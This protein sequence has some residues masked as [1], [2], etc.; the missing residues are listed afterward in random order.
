MD[1]DEQ[2]YDASEAKWEMDNDK[3]WLNQAEYSS[4]AYD[5]MVR[6][7]MEGKS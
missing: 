4:E 5:E 3:A 7:D 2:S 1:Y 6:E